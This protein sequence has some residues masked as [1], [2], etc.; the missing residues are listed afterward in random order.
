MLGTI[1]YWPWYGMFTFSS[2]E[3]ERS[4][5]RSEWSAEFLSESP[6]VSE[7]C[8]LFEAESLI[9]LNCETESGG[10][11]EKAV[12]LG[13][14]SFCDP[15]HCFSRSTRSELEASKGRYVGR[16]AQIIATLVSNIEKY[17]R[18]IKD[19]SCKVLL[20]FTDYQRIELTISARFVDYCYTQYTCNANTVSNHQKLIV[21]TQG[22]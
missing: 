18:R 22:I 1:G 16:Q 5:K 9:S 12:R 14:V 3:I 15:Y 8:L 2:L 10:R 17:V 6:I 19:T 21:R 20:L 13:L 4:G 11:L 7:K